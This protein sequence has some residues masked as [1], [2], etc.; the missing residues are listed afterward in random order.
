M[1]KKFKETA[2]YI[3]IF[4][5]IFIVPQLLIYYFE[6][7]DKKIFYS[8]MERE[9][10][11]CY[12]RAKRDSAYTEFCNRIQRASEETFRSSRSKNNFYLLMFSPILFVLVIAIWQLRKQIEEL[13]EKIND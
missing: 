10:E 1:S 2:N 3:L 13:K 11:I 8:R 7:E 12:E 5:V 4:V 6:S 9:N